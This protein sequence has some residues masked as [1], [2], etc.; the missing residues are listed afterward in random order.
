MRARTSTSLLV[1]AGATWLACVAC[2]GGGGAAD[3]GTGTSGPVVIQATERV[4]GERLDACGACHAAIDNVPDV[5]V[6]FEHA[7]MLLAHDPGA[8]WR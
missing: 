5:R 6:Y 1:V 7:E 4:A 3:G 8:P 2:D